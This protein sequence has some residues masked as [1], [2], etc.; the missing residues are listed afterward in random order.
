MKLGSLG[1]RLHVLYLHVYVLYH[2]LILPI[3]HT[4]SAELQDTLQT[5]ET[6]TVMLN[7]QLA[8]LGLKA[9]ALEKREQELEAQRDA[10]KDQLGQATEE[11]GM[12]RSQS[13]ALGDEKSSAEAM[14]GDL[15]S[16]CESLKQS[17]TE[18]EAEVKCLREQLELATSRISQLV[19]ENDGLDTLQGQ[20]SR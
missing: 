9:S 2:C 10:L 12:L 5:Y 16:E 15:K 18:S 4:A 6:R 13:K 20:T 19:R 8:D 3:L 17:R 14:V 7:K 1:T 11:A